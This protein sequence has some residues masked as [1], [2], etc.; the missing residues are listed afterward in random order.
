[1]AEARATAP[2]S[3][4]SSINVKRAFAALAGGVLPEFLSSTG[5]L[6]ASRPRHI[7]RRRELHA[8]IVAP[9]KS[10]PEAVKL[11][12]NSPNRRAPTT[13]VPAVIVAGGAMAVLT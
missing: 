12:K 8:N 13:R 6:G 1:M 10:I 2:A 9:P 11:I 4:K 3:C 5:E 7:H